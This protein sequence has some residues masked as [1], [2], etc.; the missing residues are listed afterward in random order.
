MRVWSE[1][2]DCVELERVADG[3][4]QRGDLRLAVRVSR[5]PFSGE[6]QVWNQLTAWLAFVREITFWRSGAKASQPR[7]DVAR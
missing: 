6:T 1:A 3:E 5:G 4:E 7:R 2:R